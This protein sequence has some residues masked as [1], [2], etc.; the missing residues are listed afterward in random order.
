MY[1][2][3]FHSHVY[4]PAIA[5]KDTLATCEFYDLVSPYEGTPAEKRALDGAV[6]ITRSLILPVAVL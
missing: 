5:R 6:G 4:P 3:D 2:I 1:Y